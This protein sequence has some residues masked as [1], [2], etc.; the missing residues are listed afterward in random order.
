MNF[1]ASTSIN[2]IL[3]YNF[4]LNLFSTW[5]VYVLCHIYYVKRILLYVDDLVEIY[6]KC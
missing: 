3:S 5:H 4:S 1:L 6:F 2:V